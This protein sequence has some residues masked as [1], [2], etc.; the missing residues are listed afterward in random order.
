MT[1]PSLRLSSQPSSCVC[2]GPAEPGNGERTACA[3]PS[4]VKMP[5]RPASH[6]PC[7]WSWKTGVPEEGRSSRDLPGPRA[8]RKGR[9]QGWQKGP[10]L[11]Q[12]G[13]ANSQSHEDDVALG[14]TVVKNSG[15]TPACLGGKADP[16]LSSCA[17]LGESLPLSCPTSSVHKTV[18]STMLTS[19][20]AGSIK[21]KMLGMCSA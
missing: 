10:P 19:Q 4:P 17:T 11:I 21:S 1:W 13:S 8:G 15:S 9:G 12:A 2:M 6:S 18:T 14:A 5:Q 20:G 16:S 3:A 7:L